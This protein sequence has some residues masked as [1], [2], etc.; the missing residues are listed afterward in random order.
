MAESQLGLGHA[1][2]RAEHIQQ[3]CKLALLEHQRIFIES[4][5]GRPIRIYDDALACEVDQEGLERLDW[6]I[7]VFARKPVEQFG[8]RFLPVEP[9]ERTY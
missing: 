7:R 5:I 2:W 3:E 6:L 9:R 1:F 4:K 8:L